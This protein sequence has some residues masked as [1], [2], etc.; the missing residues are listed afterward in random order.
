MKQFLLHGQVFEYNFLFFATAAISETE[1]NRGDNLF[2]DKKKSQ[3]PISRFQ[4]TPAWHACQA[5]QQSAFGT[6]D[7]KYTMSMRTS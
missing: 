2:F 6:T 5:A 1:N 3:W 7:P 4:I